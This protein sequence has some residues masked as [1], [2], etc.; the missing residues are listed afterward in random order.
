MMRRVHT[1]EE[2]R[3]RHVESGAT[4][5]AVESRDDVLR[6]S[7]TVEGTPVRT[8]AVLMALGLILITLAGPIADVFG[9][10]LLGRAQVS[11][12]GSKLGSFSSVAPT[13]I[14]RSGFV[15]ISAGLIHG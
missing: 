11:S 7:E 1:T 8:V 2:P 15:S 6:T 10:L 5:S 13:L 3:P 4:R 9:W 14:R 12:T